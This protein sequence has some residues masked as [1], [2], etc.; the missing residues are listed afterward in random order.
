MGKFIVR[1]TVY[2]DYIVEVEAENKDEAREFAENIPLEQWGDDGGS[3]LDIYE[4]Y[5][6][7]DSDG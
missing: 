2:V 4:V 6:E 5:E 3:G 7:E 1:A